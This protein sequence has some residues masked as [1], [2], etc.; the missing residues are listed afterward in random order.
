M[1]FA[2]LGLSSSRGLP[3]V[4]GSFQMSRLGILKTSIFLRQHGP[5]Y[6]RNLPIKEINGKLA[7]FVRENFS[8]IV[9]EVFFSDSSL[10]YASI[11]S[12]SAK[13][14]LVTAFGASKII[15][16]GINPTVFPLITIR[17]DDDFDGD[18]F[19]LAKASSLESKLLRARVHDEDIQ[20]NSFPPY[21]DQRISHKFPASWLGARAPDS[22]N[23]RK[24]KA[25]VLGAIAL[26]PHPMER[27]LFT[28]RNIF[29]GR[30][31]LEQQGWTWS[32][33]FEGGHTPRISEDIIIGA[34]DHG[35]LSLLDQLLIENNADN[36]K[37][38]RALAYYYR[39][40]FLDETERFPVLFQALDALFGDAGAATQAIIQGLQGTS[41][42][43]FTYER[44]K[45]IMSLRGSVVHGGSP[46]IYDSSKYIRY[47]EKYGDDPISDVDLIAAQTLR[48]TI[49]ANLLFERPHTYKDLVKDK[50]GIDI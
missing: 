38:I 4:G 7:D 29:G 20:S 30:A 36:I 45:L 48:T 47:F 24:I 2:S 28:G 9:N 34:A 19:F 13:S 37:H 26:L 50:L 1:E 14:K 32:P 23:A 12:E 15:A 22:T 27:Y 31:T 21:P 46:D 3:A 17:V 10:P 39:A 44:L 8:L 40:W 41:S 18:A 43:K 5:S 42:E 16:P 35:W 33:S 6:L 49:F 11:I 25:A